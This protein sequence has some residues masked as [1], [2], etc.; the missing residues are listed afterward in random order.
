MPNWLHKTRLCT[1]GNWV[2]AK[3]CP[4]SRVSAEIEALENQERS[5]PAQWERHLGTIGWISDARDADHPQVKPIHT[6]ETDE[7]DLKEV[8][9]Q[10]RVR[11]G[12]TPLPRVH[13]AVTLCA[14]CHLCYNT[15]PSWLLKEATRDNPHVYPGTLGQVS[16]GLGSLS[17]ISA[18]LRSREVLRP[19]TI[20][21]QLIKNTNL[22]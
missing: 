7:T 17:V 12:A 15:I 4:R 22:G 3:Q 14:L 9:K 20:K 16:T 1:F 2:Q 10:K 8:R 11:A 21:P 18:L 6:N 19:H 5:L 13:T